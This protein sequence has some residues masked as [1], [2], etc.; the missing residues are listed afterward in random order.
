[1]SN[2]ELPEANLQSSMP[3]IPCPSKIH[4]P[5]DDTIDTNFPVS[6]PAFLCCPLATDILQSTMQAG[7]SSPLVRKNT[8]D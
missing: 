8:V 4:H 1:M 5:A 7:L 3:R 2:R 6:A